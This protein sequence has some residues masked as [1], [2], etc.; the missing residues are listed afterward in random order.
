MDMKLLNKLKD[1]QL[2][3]A[4]I[5]DYLLF[6]AALLFFTFLRPEQSYFLFLPRFIPGSSTQ[7]RNQKKKQNRILRKKVW[8]FLPNIWTHSSVGPVRSW[9]PLPHLGL[10]SLLQAKTK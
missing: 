6:V 4:G 2:Q 3:C 10:D 9:G 1:Y 5:R 8:V 7:G